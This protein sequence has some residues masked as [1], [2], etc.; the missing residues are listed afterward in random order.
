MGREQDRRA[1]IAQAQIELNK[2]PIY[3]DTETTGLK[4]Y[5]QI[6]EICLLDHDGSIAFESLVRPTVK[7]QPDAMRLH[8]ITDVLLSSA[9]TSTCPAATHRDA[10]GTLPRK[11]TATAPLKRT[12]AYV[13]E[14]GDGSILPSRMRPWKE[15][16][17]TSAGDRSCATAPSRAR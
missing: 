8:H 11:S 7:I 1:A 2:K 16:S 4:D 14:N 15:A 9:P 6:V 13:A 17:I 12:P 10:S 3:L 5:D